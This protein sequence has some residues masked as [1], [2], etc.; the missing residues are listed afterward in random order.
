MSDLC[1]LYVNWIRFIYII[2]VDSNT[3]L[4]THLHSNGGGSVQNKQT[5][6][7]RTPETTWAVTAEITIQRQQGGKMRVVEHGGCTNRMSG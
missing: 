1:W 6:G 3:K 4:S 2:G 5:F 7:H